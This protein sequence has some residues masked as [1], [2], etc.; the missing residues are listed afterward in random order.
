MQLDGIFKRHLA[1]DGRHLPREVAFQPCGRLLTRAE[2]SDSISNKEKW[3]LGPPPA[4]P[5]AGDTTPACGW[6]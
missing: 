6:E 2:I 5:S 1:V 3:H 4:D